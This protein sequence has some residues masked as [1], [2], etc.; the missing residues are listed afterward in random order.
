MPEYIDLSIIISISVLAAIDSVNP[1]EILAGVFLFSVKKPL[2]SFFS[3]V[4][5]IFVFHLLAGYIFYY[6]FN[7]ILNLKILDSVFFDRSIELIGG[8]LLIIFGFMMKKHNKSANR[9]IIDLR[10]IYTFLLG[11]GIT[12]SA[13]PTSA[14]YYSAL[15]IIANDNLKFGSISLLLILYNLIFVFPLFILLAIYLLFRQN[16]KRIFEKVR[17]FIICRLNGVLKVIFILAGLFLVTNFV[18]YI[19]FARIH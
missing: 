5:G 3:Y 14:A 12:A 15:G 2:N 8:V 1:V 4:T 6:A 11:I 16:S 19:F 7:F 9:E 18:F 17:N 10:P 13:I